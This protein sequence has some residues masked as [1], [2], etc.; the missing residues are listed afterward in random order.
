M[1]HDNPQQDVSDLFRN[2]ESHGTTDPGDR[3][4][5][6]SRVQLCGICRQ[7]GHNRARCP[8]RR[9]QTETSTESIID[10]DDPQL[11]FKIAER[12]AR[13]TAVRENEMRI[14]REAQEKHR[15]L[16]LL[17]DKK[18]PD[19]RQEPEYYGSWH[20]NQDATA[21]K[22]LEVIHAS[23][24]EGDSLGKVRSHN[25]CTA[26]CGSG[27]TELV[28][29]LACKIQTSK[30]PIFEN[31]S[32]ENMF[33][34]TGYS[35]KDFVPDM[36][37]ALKYIDKDN[38][39]HLNDL[40]SKKDSFVKRIENEPELLDN[41]IFFIDEARLVVELGRTL[42][43]LF[44]ML[45]LT[46]ENIK[47]LNIL[48]FYID[49]TP[50][51]VEIMFNKE[52]FGLVDKHI[53]EPGENYF[54]AERMLNGEENIKFNSIEANSNNDILSIAGRYEMVK[55]IKQR[56]NGNSV[57]RIPNAGR[58]SGVAREE[59][60]RLLE[61]KGIKVYIDASGKENEADWLVD[62]QGNE[63]IK[64]GDAIIKDYGKPVVFILI[65]KYLCSKRF[66]FNK[67]HK[68]MYDTMYSGKPDNLSTQGILS[69]FWGYYTPKEMGELNIDCYGCKEHFERYIYYVD[70]E[71]I[72]NGYVSNKLDSQN[73][74]PRKPMYHN[75]T[76]ASLDNIH[77]TTDVKRH[78]ENGKTI[79]GSDL[80]GDYYKN[81]KKLTGDI[82][83]VT[84]PREITRN[85]SKIVHEHHEEFP[86]Q[87]D[88]RNDKSNGE[89]FYEL[90]DLEKRVNTISNYFGHTWRNFTGGIWKRSSEEEQRVK[91][92]KYVKNI[93]KKRPSSTLPPSHTPWINQERTF[94]HRVYSWKFDPD[95]D[96]ERIKFMLLWK[97][98]E[99]GI[100]C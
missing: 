32:R 24:D 92:W 28:D 16:Q 4:I 84:H 43:K 38:I 9:T 99:M 69:R 54:G 51:D 65:Q 19:N 21:E 31:R 98:K 95:D 94:A 55:R 93:A 12:R 57:F 29:A 72:P 74:Y 78:Y 3:T 5:S 26:S 45:G 33:L 83:S 53:L 67:T 2:Y 68:I 25:L 97:G 77:H 85:F 14:A 17:Y 27:K 35:S 18:S 70:T 80:A 11:K 23:T 61:D 48:F 71:N 44:G 6:S 81:H 63:R 47:K 96:N 15:K 79:Y 58:R 1:F 90:E 86:D 100:E 59:F 49:A 10:I 40:I 37:K 52:L 50:Q 20:D 22:I 89:Y 56:G 46:Q 8:Q 30:K 62:E 76:I 91:E 75:N 87:P 39:Y 88:H 60:K 73:Q 36:K 7:P 64:F 13:I 66:R 41:A 82:L 34:K 42:G